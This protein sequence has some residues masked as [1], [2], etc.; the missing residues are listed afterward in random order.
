M[1][2][3]ELVRAQAAP[4]GEAAVLGRRECAALP[5]ALQRLGRRRACEV[6]RGHCTSQ[7]PLQQTLRRKLPMDRRSRY[8]CRTI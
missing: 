4:C 2:E 3:G 1:R 5:A 7:H 8:F 6:V